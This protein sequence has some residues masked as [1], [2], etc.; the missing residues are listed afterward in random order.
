MR[1]YTLESLNP[2]D[3]PRARRPETSPDSGGGIALLLLLVGAFGYHVVFRLLD[4][5]RLSQDLAGRTVSVSD[6]SASTLFGVALFGLAVLLSVWSLLTIRRSSGQFT[7]FAFMIQLLVLWW[8]VLTIAIP[9][10]PRFEL[11]D[12]TILGAIPIIVVA[13]TYPPTMLTVRRVNVLRDTF[14]AAQFIYSFLD[15]VNAQVPCRPDKCGIFGTMHTGFFTQENSATNVISLLLPLAATSSRPRF[16][17]AMSLGMAVALASGSRTGVASTVVALF[18]ALYVRWQLR[19]NSAQVHAHWLLRAAPLGATAASFLLFL[20]SDP[21]TLTGRGGV[22]AA[23]RAALDGPSLLYGVPWDT[24]SV[25]FDGYLDSD[26]GQVSHILASAGAVGLVCWVLA[27]ASLLRRGRG[28]MS[29]EALIGLSLIAG[30]VVPMLTESTF[31]FSARSTG[32]ATLCLAVGLFSTRSAKDVLGDSVE[33]RW[34]PPRPVTVSVVGVAVVVAILLPITASERVEARTTVVVESD[35]A[36]SAEPQYD[37]WFADLSLTSTLTALAQEWGGTMPRDA[38]TKDGRA[39][40]SVYAKE[41]T[42]VL[43]VMA[44]ADTT[45]QAVDAADD[46]VEQLRGAVER[47]TGDRTDVTPLGTRAVT[48]NPIISHWT[49]FVVPLVLG[50]AIS[51]ILEWVPARPHRGAHRSL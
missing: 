3:A 35:S 44:Q 31:E 36:V 4:N 48:V 12:L 28:R 26:H 1:M 32:F 30:A 19:G 51:F 7:W 10:T 24:V 6:G 25:A 13:V 27:L 49:L 40:V 29:R 2:P 18:V 22:Y 16:V 37:A 47:A 21:A 20:L 23:N 46:T 34:T 41:G 8:V 45:E 38:V 9:R 15:P 50:V 33:E 14:A 39:R 5:G 42:T 43:E 11:A 17:V